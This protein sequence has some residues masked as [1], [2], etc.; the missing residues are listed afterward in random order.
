MKIFVVNAGSS[1][2]KYQLIDMDDQSVIV[3]GLC[4]RIGQDMGHIVLKKPDGSKFEADYPMPDHTTAFKKVIE[5]MTTGETKVIDD[6]KDIS[7]VGHRIVQGGAYFKESCLVND[8]VLKR[9]EDYGK[10]APLHNPAHVQGIRACIDV[11]GKEVPQV[12]VF[13]TSFHSTMPDYAYTFPLPYKYYEEY[14]I[15]RYGAHGTSHRYISDRVINECGVGTPSRVITCHLGNGSSITAVKDGKCIDTSMGLTPLDGFMMGTRCGAVDPSAITYIM[16]KEGLTPKQMDE[17]MNKQSGLYGV[18][19]VSSDNRDVVAAAEKGNE[20][21]IL[22]RKILKYQISKVVGS[23]IAAL[24]GLDAIAFTGGLGENDDDLR[25][26]VLD[27]MS[28]VG[29]KYDKEK[30]KKMV[31]GN[32]GELTAEGSKVRSF[33]LLTDEEMV[34]AKDTKAIVEKM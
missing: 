17:I 19:G 8:D 16:D 7:A 2:L 33:V 5:W 22:A 24:G 6:L 31:Q 18:S 11:L 3:K 21:A 10:L 34:I 14:K 26:F 1:S 28:Y 13:D 23:Y 30:N 27:S 25:E 9:I 12:V 4:E 29:L 20:R 15:R 32:E